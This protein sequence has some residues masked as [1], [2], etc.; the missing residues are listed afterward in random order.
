M[1]DTATAPVMYN[2][3]RGQGDLPLD[4][5]V[6]AMVEK[7][8]KT[9]S[10]S[11]PPEAIMGFRVGNHLDFEPYEALGFDHPKDHK[12]YN[13]D[14]EDP[15][16]IEILEGIKAS[17]QLD[18]PLLVYPLVTEK[19]SFILVLDGATRTSIIAYLRENNPDLF[20][21]V[22][23]KVFRG[24][25]EEAKAA[26]VRRNMEGR[27]RPLNDCEMM[28]AIV[29]FNKWGWTDAETCERIGRDPKKYTPIISQYRVTAQNLI[30]ELIQA[31]KEGK[32]ARQT[33]FES[34]KLTTDEQKAIAT[35]IGTGEKVTSQSVSSTNETKK[36]RPIPRINRIETT[37]EEIM[38]GLKGQR[39]GTSCKESF[40]KV[41]EALAQ[42]RSDV[43]EKMAEKE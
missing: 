7:M 31:L 4:K 3:G 2:M 26:M 24:S 9:S 21:R 11:I 41:I 6:P 15:K 17:E 30:P 36:F 23:V 5:F 1:S 18:D 25:L 39:L 33:A 16:F 42:F 20:K 37:M 13:R 14:N 19:G 32:I 38:I 10:I 12:Y 35:K 29:R 22:E 28:E 43:E 27:V 34:A 8:K 40:D